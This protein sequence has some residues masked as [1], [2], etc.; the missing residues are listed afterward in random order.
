MTGHT[1]IADH[2]GGR[3]ALAEERARHETELGARVAEISATPR[4]IRK[5]H[6]RL[7]PH[8]VPFVPTLAGKF[9][10]F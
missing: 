3:L 6:E 4:P 2:A 5:S 10:S 7:T 8:Q 9:V 1:E